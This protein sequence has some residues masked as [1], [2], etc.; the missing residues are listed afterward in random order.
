M[1]NIHLA[2]NFSCFEKKVEKRDHIKSI[3]VTRKCSSKRNSEQQE[4]KWQS[5]GTHY[6]ERVSVFLDS[7]TLLRW[8][9]TR[10]SISKLH[11]RNCRGTRGPLDPQHQ[12]LEGEK[13]MLGCLSLNPTLH[14]SF[15][16]QNCCSAFGSLDILTT[17]PALIIKTLYSLSFLPPAPPNGG[18]GIENR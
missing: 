16:H 6:G 14:T 15:K 18:R 7:R 11:R 3:K 4:I 5:G 1:G 10:S 13:E 12:S 9:R 17:N 2:G 8:I